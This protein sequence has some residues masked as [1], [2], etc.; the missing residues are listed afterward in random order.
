MNK[1]LNYNKIIEE[2]EKYKDIGYE[3]TQKTAKK[4]LNDEFP[5]SLFDKSYIN[6]GKNALARYIKENYDFEIQEPTIKL[7]PKK[8]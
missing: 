8:R 5:K 4:I 6:N 1:R 2:I 7:I 3:L